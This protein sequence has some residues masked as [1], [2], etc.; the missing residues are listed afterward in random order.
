MNLD[1]GPEHLV[2][3]LDDYP[4]RSGYVIT[5]FVFWAGVDAQPEPN[6]VEVAS[7]HRIPIS[8]LT[9]PDSPR[10]VRIPESPRPVVQIP[11]GGDLIHAPTGAIIH[12]FR[13]VAVD[14]RTV[15]ID[16]YEQPLFAWK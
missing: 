11:I 15:R 6:P 16:E 2:G 9:R 8:E 14:G 13:A 10:F 1:L 4:T 3:Q 7:I 5:P 12:P